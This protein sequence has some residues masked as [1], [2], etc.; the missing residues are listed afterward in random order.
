MSKPLTE[1]DIIFPHLSN[2]P[3]LSS[4]LSSLR[5]STLSTHNRLA[6]IISDSAFVESVA[7]AYGLPLVANERC[8]SWYIPPYLKSGSVYFKSTDG[9]MGEWSFSLRR[10]NLQLFDVV[11]KWG[12]AVV[13]DSTRRGKSMPDALSKTIPM[14]CCVMNRAVFGG[15]KVE[16]EMRLFTPPQAVGESEHA[17]MEKRIDGF[18]QQFLDIC[19]PNIPLLRS[20][21]KKPLRPIWITQKSSLPDSAPSF[22]DFHLIVLCTASRRVHGAEA[23]ESGYIQGAADDHEAWSHGLTPS[24]FWEN[25]DILMRV[26]EEDAP[27]VIAKLIKEQK[28]GG[29]IASLI[30]PTSQLY[31]SSSEDVQLAGFE[32]VISCTPEPFSNSALKDAGVKRYLNLKCQTGKL[33]SRDLR[34]QLPH[35]IPFFSS[36]Q[37][38]KT[39]NKILVCCPTGKDLSVGAALAILCLYTDESGAINTGK[40]KEAKGMDK[41]FIKQRMSWI[42]TSNAALNPSRATLQ[43]VNAMLLSSQDPKAS[44]P[45]QP[46]ANLPIRKTRPLPFEPPNPT[47]Q[48]PVPEPPLASPRSIFTAL[49]TT[50]TW[51][52]T[53]NLTSKLPSHPSG[54]V[55]GTATFTAM[56]HSPSIPIP[57]LLYA[58]EGT[59]STTTGLS[60]TARR[61][62][63]YQLCPGS[64]PADTE[65]IAVRFFDDDKMREARQ[66]GGVGSD[67]QGVGGLFVEMGEL[68]AGE[69]EKV[70]RAK[71]RETHLCGRDLYAATWAFARD[72]TLESEAKREGE[73][74]VWWE[75]EYD[76]KGPQKDYT[77][78]TRYT[79]VVE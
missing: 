60:F 19:K 54:T 70:V 42:T 10:L 6:S 30:K 76:V 29:A 40:A 36:L 66:E 51:K 74:E 46:T 43:S 8:G 26:N 22:P 67:G 75:V 79:Q 72:V 41:S 37:T 34:T 50:S 44:L 5:R 32:T 2:T 55:A 16:A 23:S 3:N 15:E 11:E 58:E 17:Q 62:Y 35:L 21:L 45:T 77:S 56:P 65:F 57:T 38:S 61:K 9:H 73:G 20:K 78:V 14:W 48:D 18:V 33:G 13:V 39:Q 4:T 24:L 53:R 52:F 49:A 63:V 69:G 68:Q 7:F 59:F 64:T 25:K 1:A 28:C 31:I 27:E 12:G 71:N 47:P